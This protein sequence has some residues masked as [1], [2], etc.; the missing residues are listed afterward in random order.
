MLW[1]GDDPSGDIDA[2]CWFE[3]GVNFIEDLI[4]KKKIR[5]KT[6][7]YTKAYVW[8][9]DNFFTIQQKNHPSVKQMFESRQFVDQE[10]AELAGT[11][12]RTILDTLLIACVDILLFAKGERRNLGDA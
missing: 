5:R 1:A 7:T 4:D 10:V 8:G 12:L 3:L 11:R 2:T 6:P 9:M